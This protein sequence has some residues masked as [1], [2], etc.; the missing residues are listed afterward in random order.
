MILNKFGVQVIVSWIHGALGDGLDF[1]LGKVFGFEGGA[2]AAFEA[3]IFLDR[4]DHEAVAAV[5]GDGDGLLEGFVLV[6]PEMSLELDVG[7]S[8]HGRGVL[9]VRIVCILG[10]FWLR[11]HPE[12]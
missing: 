8:Q 12:N 11:I 6:A 10:L 4:Q 9:G 7:N 1:S 3:L 2:V 5:A